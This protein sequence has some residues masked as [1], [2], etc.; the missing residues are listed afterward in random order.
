MNIK[1]LIE[2]K[3]TI[4]YQMKDCTKVARDEKRT[5]TDDE[6]DKFKK[7]DDQLIDLEK[8]IEIQKRVESIEASY[9]K[10]VEK[11]KETKSP[12]E[13]R[14]VVSHNFKKFLIG[15]EGNMD[16]EYRANVQAKGTDNLGGYTVPEIMAK[17]IETA[18]LAYGGVY[19]N[20]FVLRTSGGETMNWPTVND[21]G[22]TGK[23]TAESADMSSGATALTFG[24]VNVGA[25]KFDSDL[26]VITT[27]LLQ[28]SA[29]D[30]LGYVSAQLATRIHRILNTYFTTGTGSAQPQGY[31]TGASKGADFADRLVTRSTILDLIHSVDPAYRQSPQARLCFNDSTL[32]AI[33]QLAIGSADASPLWQPS[34]RDGEPSTIEGYK[35]FINQDMEDLHPTYK[36]MAFGDFGKFLIREAL[37]INVIRLVERY[38]EKGQ[39]GIVLLGRWDSK[40]LDA[41]TNPIKFARCATT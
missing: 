41:G 18:L 26:L 32:L 31:M 13:V 24:E 21:T 25:Y 14:K 6:K 11:N 10:P 20:S 12:E 3:G 27:E 39:V 9:A 5:L 2:Q 38:A 19:A 34:M 23:L 35:Y 37:P 1:E 30:I 16:P 28:D 17:E 22:N 4:I 8:N 7:W 29:F 36:P 33:K 15:G 40:L